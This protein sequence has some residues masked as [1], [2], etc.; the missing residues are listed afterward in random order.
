MMKFRSLTNVR[1][2]KDLGSLV[3][4]APTAGQFK[5][6]PEAAKILGV[7]GED[8]LAVVMDENNTPYVV[9][10]EEGNGGKLAAA[11]KQGGGTLTFSAANAWEEL[12][13]D[14][15]FNTHFSIDAEDKVEDAVE[16]EYGEIITTSYFKLTFVEKVEKQVRKRKDGS[17]MGDD[18]ED[19]EE[20]IDAVAS[21]SFES[22]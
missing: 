20:S 10:G 18:E 11:N 5:V 15:E 19:E 9:K 6:T 12:G 21:D 13:G 3:I 2:S 1:P 4:C 16:G 7:M 22:M 8:Y 17:V 14:T